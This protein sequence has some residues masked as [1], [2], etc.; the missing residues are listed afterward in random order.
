MGNTGTLYAGD[1]QWMTAASGIEHDEGRGHPGGEL[2][3]FQLWVNL[4]KAHKMDPP[5]YQDV[6]SA[7]IPCFDVAPGVRVKV[8]AGECGGVPAV[9]QTK[10]PVQYLDFTVSPGASYS[11]PVPETMA[12]CFCY[13]S[14]GTGTFGPQARPA[15]QGAMVVFSADGGEVIFTG[16]DQELSFLLLAGQP[17]REPVARQGPFVMNTRAELET[18]FREYQNGT[19][20]KEK[21]TMR[22]NF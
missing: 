22:T 3:G 4:P 2:H 11:H 5:A 13:V 19:F 8:L 7:K 15:G 17:I 16:G 20:I 21:A 12:T 1:L 10:V 18:A 14:S 9:V 6:P